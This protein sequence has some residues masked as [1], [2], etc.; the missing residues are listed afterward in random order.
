MMVESRSRTLIELMVTVRHVSNDCE[1]PR[2]EMRTSIARRPLLRA[3]LSSKALSALSAPESMMRRRTP[4]AWPF[5]S[6]MSA[7]ASFQAS[8]A[9]L[10]AR[11]MTLES[12]L[13][14]MAAQWR[15][16]KSGWKALRHSERSRWCRARR[17][18]S[19]ART[20]ARSCSKAPYRARFR[21]FAR[22]ELTISRWRLAS[23]TTSHHLLKAPA[24]VRFMKKLSALLPLFRPS[25]RSTASSL[26]E[27]S[28]CTAYRFWMRA[29]ETATLARRAMLTTTTS[30]QCRKLPARQRLSQNF[31][32]L[33]TRRRSSWQSTTKSCQRRKLSAMLL[34]TQ[35]FIALLMAAPIS[36]F[37]PTYSRHRPHAC[38]VAIPMKNEAAC[39]SLACSSRNAIH[40]FHAVASPR[41]VK[42][43][44]ACEALARR[45]RASSIKSSHEL[46]ASAIAMCS[47]RPMIESPLSCRSR[48]P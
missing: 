16:R 19:L 10:S 1:R 31:I 2:C 12:P 42:N 9:E 14:S 17:L 40:W 46:N 11:F 3:A 34:F 38:R 47:H 15:L 43:L 48:F 27:C 24:T 33:P 28:A 22:Q 6:R 32:D 30:C 13:A 37:S 44:S 25:I 45:S 29:R 5:F 36:A 21:I 7:T 4:S 26:H 8:H 39:R 18:R 23:S 41:C 35:K 20:L